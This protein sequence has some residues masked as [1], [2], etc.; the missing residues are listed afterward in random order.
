MP[1]SGDSVGDLADATPIEVTPNFTAKKPYKP[2]RVEATR[3]GSSVHVKVYPILKS[4]NGAGSL[5]E[6]S[7][8][9]VY[10]FSFDGIIQY[11]IDGGDWVNIGNTS[12]F[13][14]TNSS[15][16]TLNVEQ[17]QYNYESEVLS[18]SVGTDD[19]TYIGR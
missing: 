10:P 1:F 6:S 17:I 9:D 15:S 14:I 13:D 8:S 16:F 19:G 7:Y 11:N 4:H 3:N 2:A 18:V 5:S 12:E